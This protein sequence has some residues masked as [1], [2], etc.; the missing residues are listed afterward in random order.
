MQGKISYKEQQKCGK[1]VDY[2]NPE[3]LDEE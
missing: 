2:F 1:I 3:E